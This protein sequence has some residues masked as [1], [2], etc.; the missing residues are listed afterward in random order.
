MELTASVSLLRVIQCTNT[1]S[2]DG[3]KKV[4][5]VCLCCILTLHKE[6]NLWMPR[7]I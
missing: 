2:M 7:L 5:T 3:D 4:D 1:L 6:T